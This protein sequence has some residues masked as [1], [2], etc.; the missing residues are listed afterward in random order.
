[1]KQKLKYSIIQVF[2][3]PFFF[4]A[5][6]WIV[7]LVEILCELSFVQNGLIPRKISGL[8]GV[9]LSPFIHKN[10]EHL[11]N[12]TLPIIIL[13]GALCFFYKKNYKQIFL[14]LFFT[15]GILLWGIGRPNFHIGASGIIY[16]LASFIFF[17]GLI[18]KNTRLS[19]MSLAVI[20]IY[21]SLFWGLFPTHQ[22]I[23]WE[24]HLSGFFSGMI[25]SWFY[26]KDGPKRKKY[27][28][29]IDEELEEAEEEKI[30]I[31]YDYKKK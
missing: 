3:A 13:G 9:L 4:I 28:W 27:Q 11:I 24:G 31:I 17:S 14:W 22:E 26:R 21:G 29:E 15:S 10:I 20:F 7:K 18:S 8:K 6:L 1:M 19:A 23:S 2:K 30:E 16:A 25:I 12:N 5:I